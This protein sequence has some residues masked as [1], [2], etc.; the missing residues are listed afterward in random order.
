MSYVYIYPEFEDVDVENVPLFI[1]LKQ[2]P[3]W[4]GV[5]TESIAKSFFQ[6][7]RVKIRIKHP[8]EKYYYS[9]VGNTR[10]FEEITLLARTLYSEKGEGSKLHQIFSMCLSSRQVITAFSKLH[11]EA[12]LFYESRVKENLNLLYQSQINE[13]LPSFEWFGEWKIVKK[14]PKTAFEIAHPWALISM[15]EKNFPRK[16]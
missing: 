5:F 12:R 8:L 15:R 1:D 7:K 11:N 6:G 4:D 10:K 14:E 16:G 3:Y 2:Y 13:V 9:E